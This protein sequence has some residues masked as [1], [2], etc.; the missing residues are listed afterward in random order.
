MSLAITPLDHIVLFFG[1]S[2]VT[3]HFAHTREAVSLHKMLACQIES[4]CGGGGGGEPLQVKYATDL[5]V[6]R[7]HD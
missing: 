2:Q 3:V 7:T 5:D 6:K 4:E 1:Q